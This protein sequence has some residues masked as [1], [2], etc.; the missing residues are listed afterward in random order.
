M[1]EN[2]IMYNVM[3][4]L[5]IWDQDYKELLPC[6]ATDYTAS[7]DG[8]T[9]TINLRDDVYFQKGKFQDGRKMTAEDVKYSLER[10]KNESTTDRIC[11]DFF[12]Y[13]EVTSPTQVVIHMKSVAGPFINQLAEIGNVILPKEEVEGWGDEFG[14]HIVGTGPFTLEEMVTDE[15]VVLKK[16]DNYWGTEPNVDGI[17]FRII[18]DS[19]Q[20]INAVQT[21][22]VDIA[23]YLQG[24]A[25]KRAQ[26]AGLLLQTASSAVT[27]VRFNIQ[28]GPTANADVRKALTMAV[29][30]D[31]MVAGIYQYGEGTRAYQPLPVYSFAYD[32]AYNDL[33]PSYDPEGA[34]KLLAEAGYPDGFKTSIMCASTTA[35]LKQCEFLQQQ[36]AQVGIDV[37][38]NALES[39]VVNQKIQDV[40]VP[41][42]EAEVDMYVIG[43]SPSTG[44][45]DW[46]I[47]PLMAIESEP[48]ASYNICYYENEEVDQLLKDALSTADDSKRAEAYAKA[49]D[50]IWEES[51][52]VCLANDNNTWASSA[53]M[54]DAKV[55]P[56]NCLNLRNAKLAK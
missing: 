38:I 32:T 28:N 45:A 51:P 18:S 26:D 2:H 43:W 54:V 21:G 27:Y 19:N 30:I 7:D 34:K 24:E 52:L 25:I 46:G 42:S 13:C 11:R 44:D 22:E 16:N 50:I 12:D 53:K 39:A 8:L 3:E 23:M 29:D 56:D 10:S 17:E 37:Q 48:P 14:S 15:K 35:N 9:Y 4:T 47:R 55:F 36:L 5:F 31:S 33:V 20:A 49:Q 41:G 40:D 6:L 1:Y